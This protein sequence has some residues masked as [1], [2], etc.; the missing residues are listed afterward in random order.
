MFSTLRGDP[1]RWHVS[2]LGTASLP[3]FQ[4]VG[5]ASCLAWA[6][7]PNTMVNLWKCWK[8]LLDLIGSY[9]I[10]LDLG[11]WW[12]LWSHHTELPG[13]EEVSDSRRLWRSWIES[14]GSDVFS[15]DCLKSAGWA[16]KGLDLPISS[17]IYESTR[18]AT[19]LLVEHAIFLGKPFTFFPRVPVPYFKVKLAQGRNSWNHAPRCSEVQS[20]RQQYDWWQLAPQYWTPNVND[21]EE[22]LCRWTGSLKW[23]APGCNLLYA[24]G[25]EMPHVSSTRGSST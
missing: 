18:H 23:V 8:C 22:I 13:S 17:T 20:F 3:V 21:P 2:P 11:W 5:I 7:R 4:G 15:Q 19:G 10:L 24:Y 9:W 25:I 6:R 14:N 16:C 12:C 1:R